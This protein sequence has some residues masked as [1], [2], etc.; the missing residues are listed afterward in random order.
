VLQFP[1]GCY[2]VAEVTGAEA[3]MTMILEPMGCHAYGMCGTFCFRATGHPLHGPALT[4][5]RVLGPL[6]S[7][8]VK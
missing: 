1:M 2:Y 8:W 7:A 6:V 4:K 3:I 5:E